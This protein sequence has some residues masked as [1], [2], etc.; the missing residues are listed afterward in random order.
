[1]LDS[2]VR[3]V[4]PAYSIEHQDEVRQRRLV[5]AAW[6]FAY[7]RYPPAVLGTQE[8][9]FEQLSQLL[10]TALEETDSKRKGTI[11]CE[12]ALHKRQV[13]GGTWI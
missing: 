4:T 6:V 9:L 10:T 11:R 7:A 1:M 12:H 13:E 2:K 3:N 8:I 5:S